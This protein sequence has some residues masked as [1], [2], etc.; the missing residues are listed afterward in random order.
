MSGNRP[1]KKIEDA[2]LKKHYRTRRHGDGSLW[3]TAD[4]GEALD[5]TGGAVKR[6]AAILGITTPGKTPPRPI[7]PEPGAEK[8]D[9][10]PTAHLPGMADKLEVLVARAALGRPIFNEADVVYDDD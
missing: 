8:I 10:G 5:R 2:Y 3:T 7:E 9:P 4:H 6:R 1:W